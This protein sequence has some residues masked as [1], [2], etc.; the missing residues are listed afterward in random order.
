MS[1]DICKICGRF[2]YKSGRI[3]CDECYEKDKAEYKVVRDYVIKHRGCSVME[4]SNATGI[5]VKTIY[6]FVEEGRIDIDEKRKNE[7]ID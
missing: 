5:P 7:Q 1:Y 2:F 6:R 3:Y 4:V